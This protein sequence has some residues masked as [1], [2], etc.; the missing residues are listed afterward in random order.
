VKF[1]LSA[2]PFTEPATI[3]DDVPTPSP[4][5]ANAYRTPGAPFCV[6]ADTVCDSPEGHTKL[7]GVV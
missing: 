4:H 2:E 5:D 3:L 7:A 6:G 1:A